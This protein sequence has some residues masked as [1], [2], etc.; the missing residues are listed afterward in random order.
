M[1][2]K[3]I[4]QLQRA[5]SKSPNY[6]TKSGYSGNN[7][8]AKERKEAKQ[9]KKQLTAKQ[10]KL[11]DLTR[12]ERNKLWVLHDQVNDM[13]V[14]HSKVTRKT[15][16]KETK[17]DFKQGLKA[18][19]IWSSSSYESNLK[20]A[21]TFVKYCVTEHGIEELR[22][23]RPGMLADFI[24]YNIS[25]NNSAK[26]ISAYVTAAKKLGEFG[27]K[28][29]LKRLKKLGASKSVQELV[30][31]YSA[32]EYRRGKKDGYSI[33]DVQVM[34]KKAG[35]H[36]SPLH[37]AAIEVLG[38]SGTR[39]D[40]F[41]KV[42][43]NH[44]DFENNRIYLTDPGMTKGSRPRFVPVRE[45]TMQLLKEIKDLNLHSDDNERI[46][47]S[48]MSEKQTRQFVKEC[49]RLG[50]RGYAAIHDFRRSTVKYWM[51]EQE[52]EFKQNKLDKKGLVDKIMAH[53]GVDERLNP[54]IKVYP[55]KRDEH[56]NIMWK[57]VRKGVRIPMEDK[58]QEPTL[59]RKYVREDL[60]ERRIDFLKNL[61]LSQILG[62]NRTDVTYIYVSKDQ[63][64]RYRKK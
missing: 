56:G 61:H 40:E 7:K 63:K 4:E 34:S 3:D 5:F 8:T 50:K 37:K 14:K 23:I 47:G 29:G 28:E 36:F 39:L 45:E 2:E 18:E 49:A 26:T 13:F 35:E 64:K 59:T 44:L 62:H 42:K 60:M 57:T 48:K 20:K 43:W 30:P 10:R 17:I 58:T 55:A 15:E 52:K 24:R 54:L 32:E 51:R 1:N 12:P 6:K 31:D 16:G 46:W 27:G 53:V 41:R 25:K 22:D 38:Y 11:D 21:K 19:G 9:K 33:T